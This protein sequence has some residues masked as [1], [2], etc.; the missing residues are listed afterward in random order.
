MPDFREQLGIVTQVRQERQ[1]CD[2]K[3][4]Q[5][6]LLIQRAENLQI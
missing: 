2:E 6:R 3:L 1:N 5:T 4:Y